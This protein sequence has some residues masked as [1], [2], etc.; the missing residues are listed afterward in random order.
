[1]LKFYM[2]CLQDKELEEELEN[3]IADAKEEVDDLKEKVKAATAAEKKALQSKHKAEKELKVS[4][5]QRAEVE[6]A[7][8]DLEASLRKANGDVA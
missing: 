2:L 7:D 4:R 6:A 5:N 1:M 8:A 3:A